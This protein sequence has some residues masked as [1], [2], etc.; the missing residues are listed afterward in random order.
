ML[1]GTPARAGSR[2]RAGESVDDVYALPEPQPAR[3]RV[4]DH[5]ARSVLQSNG[6][7]A[8]DGSRRRAVSVF[9]YRSTCGDRRGGFGTRFHLPDRLDQAALLAFQLAARESFQ[10]LRSRVN[11]CTRFGVLDLSSGECAAGSTEPERH[12][13]H[14]SGKSGRTCQRRAS[15]N[16]P[17]QQ[18]RGFVGSYSHEGIMGVAESPLRALARVRRDKTSVQR[19][20]LMLPRVAWRSFPERPHSLTALSVLAHIRSVLVRASLASRPCLRQGRTT[21]RNSCR[22]RAEHL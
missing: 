18:G 5:A 12:P 22:L 20:A 4:H 8:A 1:A 19:A 14:Q 7:L 10:R 9:N 15:G 3:I 21:E 11:R 16:D 6:D 13:R 2:S 17:G